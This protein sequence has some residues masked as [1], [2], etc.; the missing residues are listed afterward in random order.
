MTIA[1][2][3]ALRNQ[4]VTDAWPTAEVDKPL[5]AQTPGVKTI[6]QGVTIIELRV[7]APL[8]TLHC[9]H[10]ASTHDTYA[11]EFTAIHQHAHDAAQAI[12][13]GAQTTL[14]AKAQSVR[15]RHILRKPTTLCRQLTLKVVRL[16]D[17]GAIA[18]PSTILTLAVQ[19]R[20]MVHIVLRQSLRGVAAGYAQRLEDRPLHV[21]IKALMGNRFD[22]SSENTEIEIDIVKEA[23]WRVVLLSAA[24]GPGTRR[25]VLSLIIQHALQRNIQGQA[26]TRVVPQR[27]RVTQQH[28][29]SDDTPR[30]VGVDELKTQVAA[31][32]GIK[33]QLPCIHQPHSTQG[34][35]VLGDGGDSIQRLPI[36]QRALLTNAGGQNTVTKLLVIRHLTV[37][38]HQ[39]RKAGQGLSGIRHDGMECTVQ[40]RL[41]C[42]F[43]CLGTDLA[44]TKDQHKSQRGQIQSTTPVVENATPQSTDSHIAPPSGDCL[45]C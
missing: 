25:P 36:C 38:D 14:C 24:L 3:P 30:K 45:V 21:L 34:G 9:G 12:H 37:T 29:R 43:G 10:R 39:C 20:Q 1:Q 22:D 18:L 11:V 41:G 23:T 16:R 44:C 15:T 26:V 40:C 32:V 13:R 28:A 27:R 5:C 42:S 2:K 19:H 8:Q 35:H 33:V 31:D 6:V 7:V 17:P 4:A